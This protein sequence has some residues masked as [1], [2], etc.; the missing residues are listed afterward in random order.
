MKGEVFNLLKKMLIKSKTKNIR[1]HQKFI[2]GRGEIGNASKTMVYSSNILNKLQI[3]VLLMRVINPL[4][5]YMVFAF[6]Q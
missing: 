5:E 6:Q 3:I 2:D 4:P 1:I